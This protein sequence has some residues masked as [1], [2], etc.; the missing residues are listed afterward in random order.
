MDE[1]IN[2]ASTIRAYEKVDRFI[3]KYTELLN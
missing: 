1:S 3:S 2:G